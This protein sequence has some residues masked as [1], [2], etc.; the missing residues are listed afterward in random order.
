MV[1]RSEN[2][3]KPKYKVVENDI[4]DRPLDALD[5]RDIGIREILVLCNPW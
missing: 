2:F 4:R 3:K 5:R 1:L